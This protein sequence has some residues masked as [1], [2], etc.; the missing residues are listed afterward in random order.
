M[1]KTKKT[2]LVFGVLALLLA[3]SMLFLYLLGGLR[4]SAEE[5]SKTYKRKVEPASYTDAFKTNAAEFSFALYRASMAQ[6]G[7]NSLL[8]PLSALY[9]LGMLSMG[10]EGE[11]LAQIEQ[12]VGMDKDALAACLFALEVSLE[13]TK[14][15]GIHLENSIW[16]RDTFKN[17]V[18]TAFLQ[19]NADYFGAQIY[20]APFDATTVRDVNRWV[21]YYTDGMI[22]KILEEA[23]DPLSVMYLINTLALDFKWDTAYKKQDIISSLPFHSASGEVQNATG[24]ASS[25]SIYLSAE[26]LQGIAKPYANGDFYFV[27][28]LPEEGT[29]PE[30]LLSSLNGASWNALWNGKRNQTVEVTLPEFTY[31]KEMQL[32]EA[33]GKL[34]IVDLFDSQKANLS[35]LAESPLYCSFIKQKTFIGV[36][37]EG[38]KA[39]A[40][41]VGA[42]KC[43]SAAPGMTL[44]FDRP[45]AYAIVDAQSGLPLFLGAVNSIH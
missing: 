6:G 23:P 31:D 43:M 27:A 34:G 24:L 28:L 37:R 33:F 39:A 36:S 3:A 4:V 20:A 9:V 14:S 19:S 42:V 10:A 7:E 22:D 35:A 32:N 29:S 5:L 13:S 8:S 40:V 41:T 30:A 12:A 16:I 38:T 25:E 21:E 2:V 17:S 45:F 11:T 15:G 18:K 44:V 26:N 1:T